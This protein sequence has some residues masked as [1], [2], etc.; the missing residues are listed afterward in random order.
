MSASVNLSQSRERWAGSRVTG[1]CT[2]EI[3]MNQMLPI[4]TIRHEGCAAAVAGKRLNR[5]ERVRELRG[6]SKTGRKLDR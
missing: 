1:N 4:M 6:N 3:I 5:S 2:D